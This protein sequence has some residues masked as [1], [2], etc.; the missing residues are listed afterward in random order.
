MLKIIVTSLLVIAAALAISSDALLEAQ[1]STENPYILFIYLDDAREDDLQFMPKT[2]ELLADQSISFNNAY[3]TFPLCCP[4]RTTTLTGLYT[5][6]HGVKTIEKGEKKFRE[7]G[8]EERTIALALDPT[9]RTGLFGKYL[10]GYTNGSHVP[11]AG[12]SGRRR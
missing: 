10:N 9:Y 7:H 12:M 2:E 1:E 5:H 11:R 4:A 8:N 3:A 6:N